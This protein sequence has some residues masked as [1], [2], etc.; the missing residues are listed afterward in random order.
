MSGGAPRLLVAT[1]NPGKARELRRLLAAAGIEPL[2]L[3]DLGLGAPFEETGTTYEENARGKAEHYA[4][5]SGMPAL[6][7]DSGL[8][9]EA[10]GGGPGVLSA[11]YG[12]PGLDDPGLP[13]ERRAA[14][15]VA[16]AALAPGPAGARRPGAPGADATRLF[17]ATC[18]GRIATEMRGERGFG[19]DPIFFYPSFGATFGEI[20][21][22][23]K[24]RVSHRALAFA[25]VAAFLKTPE[26]LAF[27]GV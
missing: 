21:D 2:T 7:D 6:A 9:V 18:P 25:S 14:R 22:D 1:F 12:G 4:A 10:L 24:D 26:G 5:Q 3:S 16:V 20:P 19:Y 15:Y 17:R 11:R 23:R 13:E 27:L 8:E